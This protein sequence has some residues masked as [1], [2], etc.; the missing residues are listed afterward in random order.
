LERRKHPHRRQPEC[1]GSRAD[2]YR[3]ER[4]VPDD[5]VLELR[6][7]RDR[8]PVSRSQLLDEARFDVGGERRQVD[9]VD[10]RVVSRCF[11]TDAE[12]CAF[13][14]DTITRLIE[15]TERYCV[16]LQTLKTAPDVTVTASRAAGA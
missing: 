1:T 8:Q 12:H 10:G 9:G 11:G 15:L 3:A 7:E 16:V 6:D 14:T 2:G 4:D 13:S 5:P